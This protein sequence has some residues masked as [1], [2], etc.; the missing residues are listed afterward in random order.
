MLNRFPNIH[1]PSSS[2]AK[3]IIPTS[4]DGYND[5]IKKNTDIERGAVYFRHLAQEA[6]DDS[7]W[8]VVTDI[9]LKQV[10]DFITQVTNELW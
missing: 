9:N 6:M 3:E 7:A 4:S 10:D 5:M 8:T 1:S 2:K